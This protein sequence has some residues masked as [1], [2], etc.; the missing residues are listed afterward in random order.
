[1]DALPRYT[2]GGASAT[3]ACG[4]VSW[5]DN[6]TS[7]SDLCGATGSAS[8][9]FRATD[10]CGNFNETT[11]TFT[12]AD[13]TRPVIGTAASDLTVECDGSGKIG[14]AACRRKRPSGGRGAVGM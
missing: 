14:G 1:P 12:I 5:T 6:F 7:L 11:A 10:E 2:H 13:T 8:V 9:T 4:A 3:D